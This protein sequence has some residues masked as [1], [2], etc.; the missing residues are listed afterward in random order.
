MR[1]P[2]AEQGGACRICGRPVASPGPELVCSDCEG[3]GRPAFDRAASALR[4]EGDARRMILD[5][6][7]NRR[8]WLRDDL[9]DCLE[10][11]ARARLNVAAVDCVVPVP[12]TAWH[13][14]DRGY[15]PVGCLARPLAKRLGRRYLPRALVRC[16]NPVRQSELDER[17]RRE[18]VRDTVGVRTA[19][20]LRGRTVLVVDDILTTG[21]TLSE[22]ARQLKAAGA[23]RVWC[24]TLARA[25]RD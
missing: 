7:F 6:K 20:I 8:F 10:G 12:T 5:F 17:E 11:A 24:A 16:G 3:P 22:C 18:N 25:V 13:R 19:E 21:A 2:F 23:W 15:N 4:F 14:L 1:L 9:L